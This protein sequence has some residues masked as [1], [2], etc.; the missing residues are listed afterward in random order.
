MCVNTRKLSTKSP[1]ASGLLYT[2][3]WLDVHL[4]PLFLVIETWWWNNNHFFIFFFF[5]G[6][7]FLHSLSW[8]FAWAV[9]SYSITRDLEGS[10][11]HYTYN[12]STGSQG[13]K[14]KWLFNVQTV[15]SVPTTCRTLKMKNIL[16]LKPHFLLSSS[17]Y[18]QPKKDKEERRRRR[19]M[20]REWELNPKFGIE[21][22]LSSEVKT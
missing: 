16:H 18:S 7:F 10:N 14:L 1:N 22:L 4:T 9:G 2:L 15:W 11:G 3:I 6:L 21:I 12:L 8:L 13:E 19:R 17:S 20:C 5:F